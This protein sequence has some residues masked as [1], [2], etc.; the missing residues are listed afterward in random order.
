[1]NQEDI[2][3]NNKRDLWPPCPPLAGP[4]LPSSF[5]DRLAEIAGL[6]ATGLARHFAAQAAGSLPETD[7]E[8]LPESATAGLECVSHTSL[9]DTEVNNPRP[10]GPLP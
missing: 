2:R 9:T 4:S 7:P 1:M 6:L 10:E 8:K 3:E 5:A